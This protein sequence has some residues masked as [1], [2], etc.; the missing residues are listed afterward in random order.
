[1]SYFIRVATPANTTTVVPQYW[2]RQIVSPTQSNIYYNDGYVGLGIPNPLSRLAVDG[3][4]TVGVDYYTTEA[5]QGTL[6]VSGSVGIGTT[7]PTAQLDVAG[8]IK[9]GQSGFNVNNQGAIILDS[10]D[11]LPRE[12]NITF[13]GGAGNTC[14]NI[15]LQPNANYEDFSIQFKN[16]ND[17]T[18]CYWS[19]TSD[20]TGVEEIMRISGETG[21]TTFNKNVIIQE[22]LTV[23]GTTT[24]NNN[25]IVGGDLTV[26]GT[27]TTINTETIIS[28]QMIITNSGTGSAL[29]VNQIGAEPI[30][31][32]KDDNATVFK[33]INGGFV[34]IGLVNPSELLDVAGTIQGYGY[35]M[36]PIP[37]SPIQSGKIEYDGDTFQGSPTSTFRGLIPMMAYHTPIAT[38]AFTNVATAQPI[39]ANSIT[40]NTNTTY[41]FEMIVHKVRTASAGTAVAHTL[42]M[43]FTG[44]ATIAN[45]GY[46]AIVSRATAVNT[47]TATT[48]VRNATVADSVIG[49]SFTGLNEYTNVIVEGIIRTGATGGTIIPNLRYSVAPITT[50]TAYADNIQRDVYLTYYPI[51]INTVVN[52]GD[53]WV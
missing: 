35:R 23:Y 25:V 9:A 48:N 29:I 42:N 24:F 28:D 2:E 30:V 1:M 37:F 12:T 44:T 47:P 38:K 41:Y 40:L 10:G 33:I 7:N 27:T 50:P 14:G 4:A 6:L 53:T 45:I 13:I 46:T 31:E 20:K 39:F 17:Y 11:G 19:I 3:G 21:L 32:F 18:G 16:Q 8:S 26:N 49:A 43:S 15:F 36:L 51:G 34:G 5:G 52:I 22:N